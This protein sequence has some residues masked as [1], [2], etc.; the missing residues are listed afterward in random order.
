MRV[1]YVVKRYPRY[2]ETFIVNEILA[3]EEAG[4]EVKIF[5]LFPPNDT[6]F[7]D[8]ISRVRAPVDYL[9]FPADGARADSLSAEG[10]RA[11]DFWAAIQRAAALVPGLRDLIAIAH[12]EEAR[13]VYH[14][15]VLAEAA[16]RSGIQHLHAHFASAATTVARIAA[17]LAGVPFTFTAHAKDIFHDS[18]RPDDLRRKI[19]DAAAVVTVSEYNLAHLR[20]EFAT[21]GDKVERIYN[22]LDLSRFPFTPPG[23]RAPRIVSVGRLVEKKG[24]DDLLHACAILER[25][26]TDF[27]CL[28]IGSGPLES[29]LRRD[30]ERLDLES[31]VELA[32]PRPQ[33]EVI[34]ALRGAAVFAGPYVVASDGNRDGLPT[35]VLE[36]MALG[37]PCVST[38]VTGVPEVLHDG[39]TGLL[40]RQRDPQSLASAL[41]RLLRDSAMRVRLA[42]SARRL[43][44]S[45]FDIRR[46]SASLRAMFDRIHTV[47]TPARQDLAS[48]A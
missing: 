34:A 39:E 30:V 8:L 40:V 42:V 12:G 21:L 23:D 24:L 9:F 26:Q 46:N 36:A 33:N 22:G 15:L 16:R 6:R 2:S 38:G 45:Q 7:Q 28:I 37:T 44:E 14:A 19:E 13:D 4:L 3:N 1:G 48:C 5:S 18:V 29:A 35:V 43:I 20:R 41:E 11:V 10:V 17:R 47:T 25:R 32:G 31:R 27:H